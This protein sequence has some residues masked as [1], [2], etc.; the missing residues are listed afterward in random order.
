MKKNIYLYSYIVIFTKL[1]YIHYNIHTVSDDY[2]SVL[3]DYA[4]SG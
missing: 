3:D 2:N 4:S 1:I